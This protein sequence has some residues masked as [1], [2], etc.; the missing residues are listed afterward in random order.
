MQK[1][2]SD[3]MKLRIYSVMFIMS[4]I[5]PLTVSAQ[6]IKV[7]LKNSRS[8]GRL[9]FS[10]E[11][12]EYNNEE[13]IETDGIFSKVVVGQEDNAQSI[14]ASISIDRY[15]AKDIDFDNDIW[16]CLNHDLTIKFYFPVGT[17]RAY[18]FV[19]GIS[20]FS[21]SK[22][23]NLLGAVDANG[24]TILPPQ[25]DLISKSDTI[26]N[27]INVCHID[28]NNVIFQ[29]DVYSIKS[30]HKIYEYKVYFDDTLPRTGPIHNEF[31][32][33]IDKSQ[34]IM[35][36]EDNEYNIDQ[37]HYLWG[38]HNMLNLNFKRAIENFERIST[39]SSLAKPRKN[40]NE[41]KI[42]IR[43]MNYQLRRPHVRP[44]HRFLAHPGP[45]GT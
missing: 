23:D 2:K 45:A 27:G 5:V 29:C 18:P 26:I 12:N 4:F 44:A 17:C 43:K 38:I 14:I 15:L 16:M 9:L 6:D 19:D 7:T 24:R 20:L 40:I 35:M 32:E 3:Y 28:S 33:I 34:F 21:L 41:C 10:I 39:T 1:I 30:L 11:S 25:Y 8:S 31:S 13:I 22:T 42:M 37:V 36:L